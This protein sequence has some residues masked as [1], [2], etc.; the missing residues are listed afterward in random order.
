MCAGH[1][2]QMGKRQ[3]ETQNKRK[4]TDPLKRDYKAKYGFSKPEKHVFKAQKGLS[5]DVVRQISAIK[6]EPKWML[7]FRLKAL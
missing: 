4:A 2:K 3:L 7:D 5:E 1:I 6:N